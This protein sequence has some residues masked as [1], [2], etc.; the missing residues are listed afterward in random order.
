MKQVLT[1]FSIVCLLA[2]SGCKD[3][4]QA[5]F[6]QRQRYT[7][8]CHLQQTPA[9][10]TDHSPPAPPLLEDFEGAPKM[11]LFPRI[12]SFRP[13][14]GDQGLP[15]WRTYIDHLRRTSGPVRL[16]HGNSQVCWSLRAV[17]G[18]ASVGFFSP[19]AV[20]PGATYR[21][22][23]QIKTDLADGA[24]AG[25]GILEF[26]KFL[27]I[28]EQYPESVYRQHFQQ[29]APGGSVEGSHDW[30]PLDFSFTVGPNT[31]MV[32][33]VLFREGPYDRQPVYF[34]D[35]RIQPAPSGGQ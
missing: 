12:G 34:D 23:M 3:T 2:V 32:H 1:L 10:S 22:S 15:F 17:R 33:L 9:A 30:Q 14:S 11:S 24:K 5:T 35:I 19:L 4:P 20:K 7:V 8:G 18:S 13:E 31:R 16:P 28:G 25:A 6:E 29:A 27:W 26:D 21:V